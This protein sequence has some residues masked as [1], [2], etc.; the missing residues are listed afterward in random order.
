MLAN[1]NDVNLF[2]EQIGAGPPL[3]LLHGSGQDHQIFDKLAA[4]LQAD[5]TVYALDS[6]NHGQ[7][8]K[9]DIYSYE[10]MAED[11]YAFIEAMQ[12]KDVNMIGFSDG[13]IVSLL[14][15]INHGEVLR[16]M[17]L[18]GVNL[19]PED[20]NEKSY[21]FI[22]EN[23]EK[24][25]EPLLKLMLEQPNI[26]VA[27]VKNVQVPTFVIAAEKEIFK[28]ETFDK[29]VAALP[30][31]TSKLMLGHKHETYIVGQDILYPDLVRFFR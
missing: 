4:K 12:L 29:V 9:T 15:A 2:Y 16:K 13:A 24:T 1:V 22:K 20:L 8:E 25:Q 19:Q 5:F 7:S 26:A 10:T 14:L 30:N 18:L 6:R 23:Y 28:P 11:V 17:A 31:V 27:D 3:I 21:Q